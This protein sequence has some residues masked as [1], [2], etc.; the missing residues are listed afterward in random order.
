MFVKMWARCGTR[1]FDLAC[2]VN[3]QLYQELRLAIIIR[4]VICHTGA[5]DLSDSLNRNEKETTKMSKIVSKA[6]IVS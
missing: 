5:A 6:K 4:S 1:K 3:V 2:A